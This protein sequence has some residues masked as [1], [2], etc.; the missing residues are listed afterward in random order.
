MGCKKE[1]PNPE[2]LDPIYMD[3]DKR[4]IDS[5]KNLEAELLRQAELK[6]SLSKA[7]VHSIDVKKY[8]LD[9]A[10][11][12]KI[13]LDLDQKARFYKIRAERRKLDDRIAYKLAFQKN[14]PWPNPR[15]Y[16]D[17]LVNIRLQD[18]PKNWA[19]RVPKLQDRLLKLP[20]KAAPAAAAPAH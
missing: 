2:L 12:L 1:D 11:S 8:K 4:A 19:V 18:A 15:D 6:V 7:E 3:L 16:S 17:Y 10:K 13:S 14:E 5:A 20:P 9:L